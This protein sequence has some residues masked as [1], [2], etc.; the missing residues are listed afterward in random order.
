MIW[1][2]YRQLSENAASYE[3]AQ[4]L[5]NALREARSMTDF[6]VVEYSD[7]RMVT[8]QVSAGDV[9]YFRNI[10]SQLPNVQRIIRAAN[11]C[12]AIIVDPYLQWQYDEGNITGPRDK[13]KGYQDM[14]A[15][16][17]PT[18]ET[19]FITMREFRNQDHIGVIKTVRGGRQG[20]GTYLNLESNNAQRKDEIVADILEKPRQG[21]DGLLVQEFIPNK[22]D[23]RVVTVGGV[24]VGAFKRKEKDLSLLKMNTSQ[25][26]SRALNRPRK[27]IIKLAER[28]SLSMGIHVASMDIVR[29]RYNG[30]LY[31]VDLNESPTLRIMHVRTKRNIPQDIMNYLNWV[32][33]N[34]QV[35]S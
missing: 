21:E 16:S 26:T 8:T 14:L 35:R 23:I 17:I 7:T 28:A 31:I 10:G 29:H 27:D 34:K 19:K 20:N 24:V 4:W 6:R 5:L 15:A 3:Q 1:I 33:D 12:G 22:G 2:M 11:N 13:M 25:G 32:H 30:Q 9:V 18:P